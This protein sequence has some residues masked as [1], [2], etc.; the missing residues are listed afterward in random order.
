[1][2]Y[3][4]L[5]CFVLFSSLFVSAEEKDTIPKSE[6]VF[7]EMAVNVS[8]YNS[9]SISIEKE[10]TYGKFKFGPRAELVNL[11]TTEDYKGG[12][13]TYQMNTQFRLRLVQV[14]Y[15][16]NDKIRVGIAPLWLLGPLPKN[17]YYKT[18][19]TIY[20]HIQLKEGFSFEPSITSSSRELIQL[21]FRKMI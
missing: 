7:V 4:I 10:F 21:S 20:T 5:S 12:D 2:K 9:L 17:G 14:E 18:P 8:Y 15:Q 19:T 16:L 13:S 6:G 3:F 1:M 11:F